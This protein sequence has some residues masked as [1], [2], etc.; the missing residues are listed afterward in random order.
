MPNTSFLKLLFAGETL[1]QCDTNGMS[2]TPKPF[3]TAPIANLVSSPKQE[4][5]PATQVVEP[6]KN[7]FVSMGYQQKV[8]ILVSEPKAKSLNATDADFL[9]KILK[10]VHLSMEEVDFIN[11][12]A[13]DKQSNFKD[14]LSAK[15]VHH[16]IS[17]GVALKRLSLEILLVPYQIKPIEGINFLYADPLAALQTDVNKKKAL[18]LCLKKMFAV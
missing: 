8:L 5:L 12:D 2:V 7:T 14:M 1:Y 16:F 6:L 11:I 9:E 10:A 3:V 17:F 4:Q 13:L 18:W 15:T